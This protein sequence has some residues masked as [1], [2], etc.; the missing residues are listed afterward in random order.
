MVEPPVIT[1]EERRETVLSYIM[2]S[3]DLEVFK[4]LFIQTTDQLLSEKTCVPGDFKE[5][6]GW[7]R[8]VRYQSED[9]YFVYCG[10]LN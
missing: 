2:N 7:V 9:V 3:D 8:S 10:G 5:L 4:T 6:G 1:P